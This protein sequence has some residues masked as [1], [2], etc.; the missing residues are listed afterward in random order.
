MHVRISNGTIILIVNRRKGRGGI[1]NNNVYA[2]YIT[3]G[4]FMWI[5]CSTD[6]FSLSITIITVQHPKSVTALT[7]PMHAASRV[8]RGMKR[9]LLSFISTTY[10]P[11]VELFPPIPSSQPEAIGC[12]S[13]GNLQP[14]S[15]LLEWHTCHLHNYLKKWLTRFKSTWQQRC[16]HM[17]WLVPMHWIQMLSP[18]GRAWAST[19]AASKPLTPQLVHHQYLFLMMLS[20]RKCTCFTAGCYSSPSGDWEYHHFIGIWRVVK[21]VEMVTPSLNK[22][23]L[24]T[25]FS[26][27]LNEV[28]TFR[29]GKKRKKNLFLPAVWKLVG[30]PAFLCGHLDFSHKHKSWGCSLGAPLQK[31]SK[32]IFEATVEQIRISCTCISFSNTDPLKVNGPYRLLWMHGI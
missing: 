32:D 20:P 23:Y 21:L 4:A 1:V 30:N 31:F 10:I 2:I 6:R 25:V 17:H 3:F 12:F 7:Y 14:T 27:R 5:L 24:G 15:S 19:I 29:R 16:Q 9:C 22:I 28:V 26:Y 13:H 11:V 18:E 8:R